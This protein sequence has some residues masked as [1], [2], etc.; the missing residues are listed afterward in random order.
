[1]TRPTLP[2]PDLLRAAPRPD[3]DPELVAELLETPFLEPGEL[4]VSREAKAPA[5]TSPWQPEFFRQDLYLD[6]LLADAFQLHLDGRRYRVHG[7]FLARV[8]G[9]PPVDLETIEL[10][11]GI[12]RELVENEALRKRAEQLYRRLTS[13]LGLFKSPR[14]AQLD[15]RAHRLE[16]LETARQ[17]V[18][19]MVE[20]FA[21]A[22]SGLRRIHEAGLAIGQT[23]EWRTLLAL[24][25]YDMNLVRLTVDLS[26]GAD[27]SL[28]AFELKKLAE[29]ET[30]R[31]HRGPLQRW[32]DKARLLWRGVPLSS[33]EVASRL[34]LEVYLEL[35]PAVRSLVQV[36]GH[37]EVYLASLAFRDW[38]GRLGLDVCLAEV[39]ADAPPSFERLFNPLLARQGIV[40]VPC[41]LAVGHRRATVLI[42]GPNSGGKTRLLQALGIAQMLGQCGLFT[43]AARA[44]LPL[45][46]GLF[47]SI[48]DHEG[49]DQAEGRLGT[50]LVR[51]RE[52][53]ERARPG[54]FVLLDELCSGTNPSEAVEIFSMVL[55]LLE[56]L[57]PV[58]FI[59]THFLDFA[60][61]LAAAPPIPHLE[62]LQVEID[63]RRRS[64][65]QFVPGVADTSLAADVARRLGV[66]FEEL[67]RLLEAR[68]R[69]AGTP[70]S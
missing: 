2:L 53:F 39:A 44:R 29:N 48:L 57:E 32:L 46:Q 36:A 6:E 55:Q 18:D 47:A 63:A 66:S 3:P 15:V 41:D 14:S 35:A 16:I 23:G 19:V 20:D 21:G 13:L 43:P 17:V 37:L 11:Q 28:R 10:R 8:W 30:N 26:I 67:S 52:L 58:A 25:D 1:M 69:A 51:I 24:L 4:G 56:R 62:L 33:K 61:E 60:R 5:P 49:A 70:S 42:T 27:G 12:L 7:R 54:S 45:V 38:A 31:F 34:I 65:Y 59:S 22:A 64:T 9:H 50:E 68:G 40:P